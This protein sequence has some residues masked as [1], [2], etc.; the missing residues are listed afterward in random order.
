MRARPWRDLRAGARPRSGLLLVTA[1]GLAAGLLRRRAPG[2]VPPRGRSR[3]RRRG[4]ALARCDPPHFVRGLR[5]IG[6][7]QDLFEHG[8]PSPMRSLATPMPARRGVVP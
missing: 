7:D 6:A 5:E 1:E 8:R 4:A 2:A 3:A